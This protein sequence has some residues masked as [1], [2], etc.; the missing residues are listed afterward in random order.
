QVPS[1]LAAVH[2]DAPAEVRRHRRSTW[3]NLPPTALCVEPRDG[4]LHVFMP[5]LETLDQY[6]ALVAAVEATAADLE[7]PV[8]V[9]GAE[10]PATP[11]LRT[12]RV[13]PDPGVI[14]VNVHPAASW[15]ELED[16]TTT[17][18]DVA[19]N[20]RLATEKFLMDGRHAG[21]GGGN[22]VT[23]GGA[24]PADSPFLR[25]P[26]LLRSLVTYWQHH[27]ALSYLFSGLF[28]G[29]TSQAPRVDEGG[30]APIAEL[31]QS[32]VEIDRAAA[33]RSEERRVGKECRSR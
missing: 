24:T 23:L 25:R 8:I 14:E 30:T 13:T 5:P 19:R 9:E 3:T 12:L 26:D 22:H 18:Y 16:A 28:V 11:G 21:T 6:A 15:D 31:E 1:A 27:P 2:A 32:L 10:P 20:A 4:R 7:M 17:L 29:P 33:P